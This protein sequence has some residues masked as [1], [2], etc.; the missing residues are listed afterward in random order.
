MIVR[1]GTSA[2]QVPEDRGKS[3]C[4]TWE[5]KSQNTPKRNM[6]ISAC[7]GSVKRVLRQLSTSLPGTVLGWLLNPVQSTSPPQRSYSSPPGMQHC[8]AGS[9]PGHPDYPRRVCWGPVRILK[10][11]LLHSFPRGDLLLA[12]DTYIF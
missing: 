11:C 2:W 6:G 5:E 4:I 8:V 7:A 1:T 10:S 3:L 9:N 12:W